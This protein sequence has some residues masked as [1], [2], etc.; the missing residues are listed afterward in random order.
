M[1]TNI[2][3]IPVRGSLFLYV[4]CLILMLYTH[5]TSQKQIQLRHS[6]FS[7]KSNLTIDLLSLGIYALGPQVL[8]YRPQIFAGSSNLK[9]VPGSGP[10]TKSEKVPGSGARQTNEPLTTN[11]TLHPAGEGHGKPCAR[12]PCRYPTSAAGARMSFRSNST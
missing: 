9:S 1:R 5:L 7:K 10:G 8:T 11:Q 4:S 6:R 3:G 2:G 12:N